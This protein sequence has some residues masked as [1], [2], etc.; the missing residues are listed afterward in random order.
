MGEDLM[1]LFKFNIFER[2]VAKQFFSAYLI[3]LLVVSS[4]FIVFEF[5]EKVN[6]FIRED[7]TIIQIASYLF[8]KLPFVIQ[9]MSPV[10]ILIG[11]LISVG[12]LSQLSEITAIRSCG[13]SLFQIAH[14]L[15]L[16]GLGI[17]S[18]VF[19]VGE[20]LVPWTSER[21][22]E[23]YYIDIKKKAETGD[24]S[25]NNFWLRNGDQFLNVGLYDSRFAS[26]EGVSLFHVNPDFELDKRVDAKNAQWVSS[27]IGWNIND[28]TEVRIDEAGQTSQ[29][30]FET[31]PLT[32]NE[33]PEDL[34]QLKRRPETMSF[35]S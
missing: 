35:L 24:L 11:I 19:L 2:Y 17:W 34:Y 8:Y 20:T 12:R 32:I 5:F 18:V 4:V 7:A 26:L 6:V 3:C 25:R 9:V 21:L 28:I 23:L 16:V 1:N 14:P 15:F 33:T 13:A 31:L 30:R 27:S 29:R 22:E 10:A